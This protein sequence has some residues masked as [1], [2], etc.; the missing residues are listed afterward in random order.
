MWRGGKA[1]RKQARRSESQPPLSMQPPRPRRTR[2]QTRAFVSTPRRAWANRGRVRKS[3]FPQPS[4]I[5]PPLLRRMM[6]KMKKRRKVSSSHLLL[7]PMVEAK[8][9]QGRR[10][11]CQLLSYT[12]LQCRMTKKRRMRQPRKSMS[13]LAL[14]WAK[15]VRTRSNGFRRHSLEGLLMMTTKKRRKRMLATSSSIAKL[16]RTDEAKQSQGRRSEC[17]QPLSMQP[18]RTT[19]RRKKRDKKSRLRPPRAWENP[20]KTRRNESRL[21][22]CMGTQ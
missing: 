12:T 19:T 4:S 9:N 8:P 18:Q 15:G 11:V 20:E 5:R 3:V 17:Q 7:P 2:M 22:S 13:I 21:P 16:Q 14:V 6:T 1:N 10:S